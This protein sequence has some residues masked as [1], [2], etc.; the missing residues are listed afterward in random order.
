MSTRELGRVKL[1]RGRVWIEG[2]WW[3]WDE[4]REELRD[5]GGRC[6]RELG[7]GEVESMSEGEESER[8]RGSQR[9]GD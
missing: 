7:R 3:I 8:T 2:I 6:W 9:Q 4:E 5:K 1:G